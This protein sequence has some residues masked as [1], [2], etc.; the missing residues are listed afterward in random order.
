M[1]YI[2]LHKRLSDNLIFYVGKGKGKRAWV[3][4]GRNERWNRTVLKH[5]YFVEI[6]FDNLSESEAFQIEK[7]CITELRYFNYPLCNMTD[8]GEGTAGHSVSKSTRL[9][10]SEVHKGRVKSEAERAN[11]SKAQ[12]GKKKSPEAVEK[13]AA[14]LRGRKQSSE[15]IALRD[16]TRKERLCC[17]DKNIYVF[18]SDTDVFIGN[19]NELAV[20][21]GLPRRKFRTLFQCDPHSHAH[22]W[23]VLRLTSLLI[24]KENIK[25]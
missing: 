13:V 2:Y 25:C 11:I 24:L 21:T 5:G 9:R 1:F 7:D 14:K 23:S 3:K 17:Q 18:F 16:K 8:G 20:Y 12:R 19:R 15:T 4:S 10:I 22:G 6:L